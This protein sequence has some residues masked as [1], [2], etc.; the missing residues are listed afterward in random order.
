MWKYFLFSFF[1]NWMFPTHS[2]R[3]WFQTLACMPT[4]WMHLIRVKLSNVYSRNKQRKSPSTKH[5]QR[6]LFSACACVRFLLFSSPRETIHI[7]SF[8]G[9]MSS[10]LFDTQRVK[11]VFF[12]WK[13]KYMSTHIDNRSHCQREI[14]RVFTLCVWA[15]WVNW[16]SSKNCISY[17]SMHT[18][19]CAWVCILCIWNDEPSQRNTGYGVHD[20][21]KSM[22][23]VK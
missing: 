8:S 23:W 17:L 11:A 4:S 7:Y 14:E 9:Q 15:L 19:S 12:D 5:I 6:Y 20:V 13:P 16:I 18:K 3:L 10:L 1:F 21:S 22:I 2:E